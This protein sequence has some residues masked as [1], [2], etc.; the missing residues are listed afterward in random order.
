MLCIVK[1]IETKVWM[2]AIIIAFVEKNF[3]DEKDTWEM[4]VEKARDWLG[5]TEV[6]VAAS[7]C[8][9]G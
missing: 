2:T 4:I 7:D 1:N 5:K 8:L 3:P 9:V 6:V